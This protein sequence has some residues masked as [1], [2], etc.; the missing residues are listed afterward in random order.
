MK[1]L[2]LCG[3]FFG[4]G[5]ASKWIVL[6]GAG[7]LAVLLFWTIFIEY[8][9][10]KRLAFIGKTLAMCTVFFFLIP[11]MIYILSY[12]P[13]L[14]APGSSFDSIIQNQIR[15]LTYHESAVRNHVFQSSWFEWPL[16]TRPMWYYQGLDVLPNRISSIVAMGNPA[17]W[18]TGVATFFSALY[19]SIKKKHRYMTVVFVAAAFQYLIWALIPR[20]IFI[21]HFY[22]TV[23]FVIFTIVYVIKHLV[24]TSSDK[25]KKIIIT[26][27]IYVFIVIALFV[28]FY[29]VISGLEVNKSWIDSA[30]WFPDWIFYAQ[31]YRKCI[32]LQTITSYP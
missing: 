9:E 24:E 32:K 14:T 8:R 6:F 13:F 25:G 28:W 27:C 7:G 23:P 31:Y 1:T 21:Y 12:I 26:T 15:M 11:V 20:T 16:M 5:V 10:N 18:W 3:L 19:I 2:F 17:I 22:S 4:L 29:P 30:K